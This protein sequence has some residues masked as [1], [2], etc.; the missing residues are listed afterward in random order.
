MRRKSFSDT[1]SRLPVG[2]TQNSNGPTAKMVMPVQKELTHARYR[3]NPLARRSNERQVNKPIASFGRRPETGAETGVPQAENRRPLPDDRAV[4]NTRVRDFECTGPHSERERTVTMSVLVLVDSDGDGTERRPNGERRMVDNDRT[5]LT[6]TATVCGVPVVAYRPGEPFLDAVARQCGRTKGH[7][8]RGVRLVL[9]GCRDPRPAAEQ[10]CR[11]R[12]VPVDVVHSTAAGDWAEALRSVDGVTVTG[13]RSRAPARMTDTVA[14]AIRLVDGLYAEYRKYADGLRDVPSAAV[15]ADRRPV[16]ESVLDA[17]G[18]VRAVEPVLDAVLE[19]L[20]GTDRDAP[21]ATTLLEEGRWTSAAAV[22][23]YGD[24]AAEDAFRLSALGRCSVANAADCA[25]RTTRVATAFATVF[26]TGPAARPPTATD[27]ILAECLVQNVR[28]AAGPELANLGAEQFSV[29]LNAKFADTRLWNGGRSSA[30]RSVMR[31]SLF[32]PEIRELCER[33]MAVDH[34]TDLMTTSDDG[35]GNSVFG[36]S[37]LEHL[38]SYVLPQRLVEYASRYYDYQV[39]Y[40]ALTDTLVFRFTDGE[41]GGLVERN[42]RHRFAGPRDFKQYHSEV[43]RT[44]DYM[45]S[46]AANSYHPIS[47]F[48]RHIS[49]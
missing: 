12:G 33:F 16:Y 46:V 29:C 15:A 25:R 11:E 31:S 30:E 32:R 37:H 1:S 3:E 42:N 39:R 20:C 26:W 49:S 18:D 9:I 7:G 8:D 40:F 4:K 36:K 28:A 21:P 24:R 22:V 45:R 17:F 14:D 2:E 41:R 27:R 43:F 44:V 34:L 38:E 19:Q 13:W 23:E 5:G 48:Q 35:G 47:P 10:L 6:V